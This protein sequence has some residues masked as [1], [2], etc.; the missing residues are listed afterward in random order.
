MLS[1][2]QVVIIWDAIYYV[3]EVQT[4]LTQLMTLLWILW[5][6]TDIFMDLK[7]D[8]R[9][10][11]YSL[12]THSQKYFFSIQIISTIIDKMFDKKHQNQAELDKRPENFV[13]CFCIRFDS[14]YQKLI[15]RSVTRHWP[16]S[17]ISFEISFSFLNFLRS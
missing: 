15:F 2:K 17:P 1:S 8:I 12:C 4:G 16:V 5:C 10:Y 3:F 6:W 9:I 7:L 13:I 14:Y 11:R